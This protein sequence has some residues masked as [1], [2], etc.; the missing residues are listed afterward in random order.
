VSAL[1][2]VLFVLISA[3]VMTLT[4]FVAVLPVVD[5]MEVEV[6]DV[7]AEVIAVEAISVV[8]VAA[9]ATLAVVE[10]VLVVAVVDSKGISL[11]SINL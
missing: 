2:A 11:Y 6:E 4:E 5:S 9:E 8:V 3:V 1:K 10:V 7:A